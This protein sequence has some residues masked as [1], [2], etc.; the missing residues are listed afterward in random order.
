MLIVEHQQAYDRLLLSIRHW[1]TTNETVIAILVVGSR[2]ARDSTLDAFSDLDLILF[3]ENSSSLINQSSWFEDIGRMWLSN[4]TQTGKGHPEWV[5]LFSVGLKVDFIIVEAN[6]SDQLE[7]IINESGYQFVLARG[8]T[9]SYKRNSIL[10]SAEHFELEQSEISIPASIIGF[11]NSIDEALLICYQVTRHAVRN[12][13]WRASQ[14]LAELRSKLL[15]LIEWQSKKAG[16]GEHKI[17]YEGRNIVQWADPI[18]VSDL[19]ALFPGFSQQHLLHS[20]QATLD[21]VRY[22]ATSIEESTGENLLTSG[23]RKVM[24]MIVTICERSSD[25][26]PGSS[27]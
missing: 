20:V 14:A 26:L 21:I 7:E 19:P 15:V 9:I 4:L 25:T 16:A 22:L 8:F 18:I 24:N 5:V 27:V 6:K 17:W 13:L 3:V 11:K 10:L 1:A 23:R 2:A 12:D